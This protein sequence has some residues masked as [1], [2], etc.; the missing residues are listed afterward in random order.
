MYSR[1][2]ALTRSRPAGYFRPA[3]GSSSWTKV[4]SSLVMLLSVTVALVAAQVAWSRPADAAPVRG[5]VTLPQDLKSARR[6]RGYWRV[7][8][9]VVPIA[10]ATA[11]ADTVVVLSGV[12]AAAPPARTVTVDVAERLA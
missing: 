11:R 6:F 9:G 10:P 5:T 2:A 7:E 1:P 4:R 3:D 8:N 12:K